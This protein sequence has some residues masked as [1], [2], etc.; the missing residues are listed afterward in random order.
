MSSWDQT[1][2]TKLLTTELKCSK[3]LYLASRKDVL[4]EKAAALDG[5]SRSELPESR[6][7]PAVAT[8]TATE[9]AEKAA[10]ALAV[11]NPG[12]LPQALALVSVTAPT[13]CQMEGSSKLEESVKQ[14]G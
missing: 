10:L 9:R 5:H 11:D 6:R 2:T 7:Q 12:S 8:A 13:R 1:T 3:G 14:L 4:F